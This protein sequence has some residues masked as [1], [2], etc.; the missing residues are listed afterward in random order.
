MEETKKKVVALDSS[1]N[2]RKALLNRISEVNAVV[3][4][5]KKI[6]AV[7]NKVDKNTTGDAVTLEEYAGIGTTNIKKDQ[8][9]IVNMFVGQLENN[10]QFKKPFPETISSDNQNAIVNALDSNL[11]LINIQVNNGIKYQKLVD[12]IKSSL[13][14]VNRYCINNNLD[15]GN[16]PNNIEVL[17]TLKASLSSIKTN[18]NSINEKIQLNGSYGNAAGF[19]PI[20]M[21]KSGETTYEQ[22]IQSYNNYENVLKQNTIKLMDNQF[23]AFYSNTEKIVENGSIN[24]IYLDSNSSINKHILPTVTQQSIDSVNENLKLIKGGTALSANEIIKYSSFFTSDQIAAY[25]KLY[26]DINSKFAEMN[27]VLKALE[28]KIR[29]GNVVAVQSGTKYIA[30]ISTSSRS[31]DY[32]IG[33]DGS[34]TLKNGGS[35][36]VFNVNSNAAEYTPVFEAEADYSVTLSGTW[37]NFKIADITPATAATETQAEIP[38]T[39]VFSRDQT[40]NLPQVSVTRTDSAATHLFNVLLSGQNI[41]NN[42]VVTMTVTLVY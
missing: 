21:I 10:T 38:G 7:S 28:G 33:T 27:N 30:T 29:I 41:N 19:I 32:T 12:D 40:S 3:D 5:A 13:D 36:P 20:G 25:N 24:S 39:I 9:S 14:S 17:N 15:S 2:D 6:K 11:N 18:M 34:V 1:L 22:M 4:K 42:Y 8:L 37:N 35:A 31:S 26:D 16:G 23:N